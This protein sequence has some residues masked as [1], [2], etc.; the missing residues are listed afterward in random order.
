M[1][2]ALLF[3]TVVLVTAVVWAGRGIGRRRARAAIRRGPGASLAEA[4]A[5]SSF[6]TIDETIAARRC[7]CGAGVHAV[8]EGA[9]DLDGRR[10]RY[11]RVECDACED[12]QVLYFDVTT[13]FH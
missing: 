3:A 10:F 9:R 11:A 13:I 2:T 12:E 8:G 7:H 5:V 6:D 4:I 1:A